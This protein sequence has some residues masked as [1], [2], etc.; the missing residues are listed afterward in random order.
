MKKLLLIVL[1][2]CPSFFVG[3]QIH[4]SLLE[5]IAVTNDTTQI[6]ALA[7]LSQLCSHEKPD[8]SLLLARQA[9]NIASKQSNLF[10]Q[11][12]AHAM[13][14]LQFKR[15]KAFIQANMHCSLAK[16]KWQ[17]VGDNA[18]VATMQANIGTVYKNSEQYDS[19]LFSHL[20][21]FAL[22]E[23]SG[24]AAEI[25]NLQSSI[26]SRYYELKGYSEAL[27]QQKTALLNDQ[28][29]GDVPHIASLYSDMDL[30]YYQIENY[31]QA[32]DCF[33]QA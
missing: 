13:L 12:I 4:D 1:L 11:A 27:L 6:E 7:S 19:S 32:I 22:R 25:A 17:T 2:S 14:G 5:R 23:R 18:R 26:T 24:T 33:E 16:T 21:A 28:K 8:S 10:W 30:I 9:V 15:Q 3:A 20:E 31:K 29:I